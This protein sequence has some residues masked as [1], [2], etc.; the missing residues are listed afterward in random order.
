MQTKLQHFGVTGRWP[1]LLETGL[2]KIRVGRFAGAI[3]KYLVFCRSTKKYLKS[4]QKK[5]SL[6]YWFAE[7][8]TELGDFLVRRC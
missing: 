2:Q 5:V 4:L 6:K 7:K 1:S 8:K 3:P